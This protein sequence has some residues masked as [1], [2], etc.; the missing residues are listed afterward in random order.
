MVITDG[1][2]VRQ[3][4]EVRSIATV[5]VD[6]THQLTTLPWVRGGDILRVSA[7]TR[8][9]RDPC[10]EIDT[11]VVAAGLLPHLEEAMHRIARGG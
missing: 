3:L 1:I 8:G 2:P 4:V 7:H 11:G 9:D 5:H 10:E 6:E